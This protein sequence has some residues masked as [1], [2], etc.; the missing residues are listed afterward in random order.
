MGVERRSVV[1]DPLNLLEAW[2]ALLR[3][4]PKPTLCV[5]LALLKRGPL[6]TPDP[7]MRALPH[8]EGAAVRRDVLQVR[9]HLQPHVAVA[10]AV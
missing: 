6:F 4:L 5:S 8:G 10:G 9:H 7:D 2:C 3:A 1:L